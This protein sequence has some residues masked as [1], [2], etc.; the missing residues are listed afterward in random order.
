MKE[1]HEM[2]VNG[3]GWKRKSSARTELIIDDKMIY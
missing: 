2:K 3:K 1:Q